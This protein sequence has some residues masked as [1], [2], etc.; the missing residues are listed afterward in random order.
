M[1]KKLGL[2]F[3]AALLLAVWPAMAVPMEGHTHQCWDFEQNTG[4]FGIVPSEYFNPY[5]DP[6][7]GPVAMIQGM[8]GKSVS[9]S[10]GTWTGEEFKIILDI[11]NQPIPREND[12]KILEINMYYLGEVSF[13]WVWDV[14]SGNSFTRIDEQK[15]QEGNWNKLYQKWYIA[16]NPREEIIAIGLKGSAA[17]MPAML[18]KICIETLCI[19]EPATLAILGAG[20]VLAAGRRKKV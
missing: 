6:D 16:P 17:G 7:G 14:D 10:N 19:P 13:S 11:P 18:D 15:T 3:A 4:R 12:Y 9:W 20:A 5:G 1:M 2:L 8:G